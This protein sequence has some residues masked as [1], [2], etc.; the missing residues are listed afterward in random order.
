MALVLLFLQQ[1][2]PATM[3][4][5]DQVDALPLAMQPSGPALC[6][7]AGKG[8]V[9]QIARAPGYL[10]LQVVSEHIFCGQGLGQ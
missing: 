8:C 5:S 3:Y 9:Y 4:K 7:L 10:G 2:T 1:S 6:C